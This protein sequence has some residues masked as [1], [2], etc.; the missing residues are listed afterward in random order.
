MKATS[1]LCLSSPEGEANYFS[2]LLNLKR[3][4]G[5]P[6]FNVINCFQVSSYEYSDLHE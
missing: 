3:D 1:L 2:N 5:D 6:F 4:N